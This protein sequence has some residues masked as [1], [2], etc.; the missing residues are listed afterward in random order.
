MKKHH[1]V[2]LIVVYLII[3]VVSLVLSVLIENSDAPLI[4]S[5]SAIGIS[6]II[7]IASSKSENDDENNDN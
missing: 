4:V 6:S 3:T 1:I 2:W 7:M 5:L